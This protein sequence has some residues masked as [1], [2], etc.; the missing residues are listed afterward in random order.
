MDRNVYRYFGSGSLRRSVLCLLIGWFGAPLGAHPVLSFTVASHVEASK[1]H[2]EK[3]SSETFP[4]TVV[5]GHQYLTI[6]AKGV[7]TIYDFARNRMLRVDLQRKTYEDYSLYSEI[8]FRVLEFYNRVMLGKMLETMKT[9]P[10]SVDAA[11]AEQLFSLAEDGSQTVLERKKSRGNTL[12]EWQNQLL[13]SAS[14]AQQTLAAEYRREYWRFIRYYAGG[15]PQVLAALSGLSGVPEK[16]SFVRTNVKTETRTLT[17]RAI[18]T[19][20]DAPYSLEGFALAM[21]DREPFKTLATVSVDDAPAQWQ[22][23]VAAALKDRDLAFS[24]ARFLDAMLAQE[25]AT[26]ASGD[27]Y[28]EWLQQV[29][30]SMRGDAP[31]QRLIS[32]LAARDESSAQ[33]AAADFRALRDL[34]PQYSDVLDVFE[35]NEL[36]SLKQGE[37]GER[38][39]LA[40]LQENPYVTGA[41]HD[42]GDY[43]YRSFRM[44]DAWG[45]LDAAR[46]MDAQ[47][48]TLRQ[49]DELEQ[50]LRAKNPDF[51]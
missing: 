50:T 35:G 27:P 24:Q 32:G 17:L 42:L 10:A 30:D 36:L 23:H 1:A 2:H 20:A 43:Y 7:R 39:L 29:R 15:H 22:A 48:P 13:V 28:L 45:C 38:L 3:S 16:M 6:D 19:P 46:R 4:L 21:P 51:F 12:F 8:A 40:A 31:T 33:Q 25:E 5:L 37:R 41:W 14:D 9:R 11:M 49:I 47:N 26:L 18:S 34:K 44:Q